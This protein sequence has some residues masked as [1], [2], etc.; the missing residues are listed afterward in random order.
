M[1]QDFVPWL[2]E[3]TTN[4]MGMVKTSHSLAQAVVQQATIQAIEQLD[5]QLD[6]TKSAIVRAKEEA[7]AQAKAEQERLLAQQVEEA[8]ENEAETSEPAENEEE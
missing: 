6:Q 3:Q 7:M 1:E 8:A 4:Q 2:L 5:G